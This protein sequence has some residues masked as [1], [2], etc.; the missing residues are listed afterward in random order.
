MQLQ[1]LM[2]STLPLLLLC[3][4]CADAGGSIAGE[5]SADAAHLQD[6]A[7]RG[8]LDAQLGDDCTRTLS[9]AAGS[10][11]APEPF[12]VVLVVDNS[13]S[14]SWSRDSLSKGL[15][16]LLS[17][18]HGSEVRF[19]LLTSTQ[20]GAS[21]QAALSLT[22]AQHLVSW[23]DAV[24]GKP[25]A[26]PVTDYR[27]TCT[28]ADG[29]SLPCPAAFN[30]DR[31]NIDGSWSFVLPP[32]I[33]QI[34]QQTS[35]AELAVAQ[36]KVAEAVLALGGGG[37]EQEQPVCTLSRYMAQAPASLPAHAV[38]VVISD[39]DDTSMPGQCLAS[40]TLKPHDAPSQPLESCTANCSTYVYA[41]SQPSITEV[42]YYQC[43]PVDDLGTEHS[44]ASTMRTQTVDYFDGCAVGDRGACSPEN[45]AQALSDC[46]ANHHVE[47]CE[48]HCEAAGSFTCS[49]ERSDNL[50]DLC[51]QGFAYNAVHYQSLADYCTHEFPNAPPWQGCDVQGYTLGMGAP[52]FYEEEVVTPVDSAASD[53]RD[54]IAHFKD[55]AGRAFG[56][57]GYAVET[58]ILDPAFSCALNAGQSYGDNLRRL[59]SSTADVFPLCNDYAPALSRIHDFATSLTHSD[60]SLGLHDDETLAEVDVVD[61]A[62]TRRKLK[63]TAYRYDPAGDA[64]RLGPEELKSNDV[65]IEVTLIGCGAPP[66]L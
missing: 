6:A 47:N 61:R 33:A 50:T 5:R 51:S 46:G 35:D 34:T 14:L 13:D 45:L 53:V 18:V 1:R 12:D 65:N 48:R 20:Y 56:N 60:F 57:A 44:E 29:Q 63:E 22:S 41:I 66:L 21:S 10:S 25:F 27:Q 4:A 15:S 3:A 64:L 9:F 52:S 8:P 11:A 36:Q 54:M 17:E 43:V 59:A 28:G 30:G 16:H 19:F 49:V 23:S 58:I 31:L 55:Q 37:S 38:F 40:Y 26:H 62:G 42:A 24:T 7:V 39:E 2:R 32:A